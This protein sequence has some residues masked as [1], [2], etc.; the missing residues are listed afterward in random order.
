MLFSFLHLIALFDNL[1]ENRILIQKCLS[2]MNKS[3]LQEPS[4]SSARKNSITCLEKYLTKLI[5]L[6]VR[7]SFLKIGI[8]KIVFELIRVLFFFRKSCDAKPRK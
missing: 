5:E 6:Q 8:Q 1:M 4:S 2:D 3:S 7:N